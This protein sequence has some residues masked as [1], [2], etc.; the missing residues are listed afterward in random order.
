MATPIAGGSGWRLM[1]VTPNTECCLC[2]PHTIYVFVDDVTY[3]DDMEHSMLLDIC[4]C[5]Y[6]MLYMNL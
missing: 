5:G 6:F 2:L 4:R 1:L 3:I